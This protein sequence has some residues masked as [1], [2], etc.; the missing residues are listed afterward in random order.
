MTK[1]KR[2]TNILWLPYEAWVA[3]SFALFILLV[4]SFT[5]PLYA[6]FGTRVY[7]IYFSVYKYGARVWFFLVGVKYRVEND[8]VLSAG[9]GVIVANHSSHIDLMNGAAASPLNT[10]ALAK[11]SLKKIP[12][13]GFL[14]STVSVFVDR[15]SAESRERSV[16][17]LSEA[18]QGGYTLFMFPEG[19]RNRTNNAL[20]PFYN[21]AFKLAIQEQKPIYPMVILYTRKIMPMQ[22]IQFRPGKITV[23]YLSP[24]STVGIKTENLSKLRQSIF[25]AMEAEILKAEP[26]LDSASR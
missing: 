7:R 23:K 9:T 1:G 14:F 8:E 19:T 4:F 22:G 25:T 24:I 12:L 20:Q 6:L 21:G 10:R 15:S 5:L 26:Y 16:V 11:I 2:L 17:A 18:L 13:L 3:V